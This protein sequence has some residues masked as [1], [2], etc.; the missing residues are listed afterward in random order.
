MTARRVGLYC[1]VST[2]GQTAENQLLALRAYASARDWSAVEFVDNGVS[3]AKVRRPQLDALMAAARARTIDVVVCVKLD[4]LARSVSHLVSMSQEWA[5]LGVDLVVLDQ[6]ID[7][8]TPTGRL[9]FVGA[10]PGQPHRGLRAR[11]V[12]QG[13]RALP[14]GPLSARGRAARRRAPAP[15]CHR[16]TARGRAVIRTLVPFEDIR[17]CTA[18]TAWLRSAARVALALVRGLGA[19]A[20]RIPTRRF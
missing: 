5:A 17:R 7:T 12:P 16:G 11:R 9:L 15:F 8:T 20:R 10:Q 1:R 19:V 13:F 3:G 18:V 4:R 14:A 2:T 6:A